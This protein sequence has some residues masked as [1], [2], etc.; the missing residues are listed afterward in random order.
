MRTVAGVV[1]F[2]GGLGGTLL[3][4]RDLPLRDDAPSGDES[5]GGED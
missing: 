4:A 1:R 5:G 2:W 3:L